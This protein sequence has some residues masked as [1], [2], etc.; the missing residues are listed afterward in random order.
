[1]LTAAETNIDESKLPPAASVQT[2][3]SRDIRPIFEKSCIRCH[4]PEKPKNGFRLDNRAAAIKGGDDGVDILPGNSAK[5][6]LIH[7]VARLVPDKEMPPDGKGDPLTPD[8]IALLRAWIDQGATWDNTAPT[9][10]FDFTISPTAG[11]TFVSGN[12]H[13]F[14]EQYWLRDEFNGGA[15]QFEIFNQPNPDITVLLTGHALLN[16]YKI[17]LDAKRNDLGFV[18]VGWEDY[19]KYYD[20]TGGFYTTPGARLPQ[21]LGK[22]LYL[23]IGKAWADFGLTLPHWP[24]MV[25]GYEYDYKRGDEATTAWGSDQIPR[26]ERNIAPNSKHLDEGTHIIKFDLDANVKG[27]AIE[28]SFRGEFYKLNTHYTNIAARASISQNASDSTHYFQGANSFRVERQFTS[29]LFGSGGYLYSRLNSDNSLNDITEAF[30]TIFPASI[31]NIALERESHVFNLNTLLGPFDG[32]TLV[33]GV[34]SEWTHQHGFGVGNLNGIGFTAPPNINLVVNPATVISDYDQ[35]TV[36]ETVRLRYTKIPFTSLFA[37]GRFEQ[38]TLGQSDAD[39]QPASTSFIENPSFHSQMSDMRAGFNTS[40]WQAVSLSA[41]YRRY[42]NE[43]HYDTN[44]VPQPVGGYPGFISWRD[45]VTDEVETKLVLRL[46]PR[47]KTTWSYQYLTTDYK[48]DTRP[49][50]NPASAIV[51]SPS[52]FFLSGKSQSHVYTFGTTFTP[53]HRLLLSGTFS[54]QDTITTT[55]NGVTISPYAGNI[56]SAL[57]SGTYIL[58]EKSDLSMSYSYS[59]ADFTQAPGT[60]LSPPPV[61]INYQ[62]HAIQAALSRHFNKHLTTRLQYGFFYYDEPTSAGVNNYRAQSVFGTVTYK[63]H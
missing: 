40:P 5:S 17:V 61:G 18:R 42:E 46:C 22:D 38:E 25:F 29:W 49:A 15:E 50:F 21:T 37:E 34:E 55:P 1:M 53:Y 32:L 47:L 4:G 6:P 45:L 36:S 57:A 63:F 20:D 3:F 60:P 43:S 62:Q 30:A 51:Y 7:Y 28:D 31:Q 35:N 14:R 9:N 41:H 8:Q 56:Y 13:K 54:Y 39:F 11:W 2:D 26:D 16:D 48:S 59:K 24:R 23:D 52:G 10:I 19:R 58:T 44:Q 33:S 12:E 27:V